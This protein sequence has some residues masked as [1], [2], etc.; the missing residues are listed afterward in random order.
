MSKPSTQQLLKDMVGSIKIMGAE[1]AGLRDALYHARVQADQLV[2]HAE[3]L[4]A[5]IGGVLLF[6]ENRKSGRY[7]VSG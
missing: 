2:R 7:S 5:H 3:Q 4:E 1:N 6:V